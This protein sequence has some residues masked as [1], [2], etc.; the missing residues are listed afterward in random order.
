MKMKTPNGTTTDVHPSSVKRKTDAG[1][2]L[3]ENMKA[4]IIK[5]GKDK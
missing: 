1:W 4:P 2:T 3:V 5:T